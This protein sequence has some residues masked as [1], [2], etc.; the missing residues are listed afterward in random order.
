MA[1]RRHNGKT[2]QRCDAA[3]RSELLLQRDGSS[4]T[5]QAA[6]TLQRR[7]S[8]TWQDG[9]TAQQERVGGKTTTA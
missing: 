2:V 3:K 5:R 1:R 9:K 6:A 4:E 7:H 8:K